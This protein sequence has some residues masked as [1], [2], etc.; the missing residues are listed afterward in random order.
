MTHD[1]LRAAATARELL[2]VRLTE[3]EGSAGRGG[4][5]R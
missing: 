3:F 2:G 1:W 5:R 4:D